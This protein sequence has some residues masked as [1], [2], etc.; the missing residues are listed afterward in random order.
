M[1]GEQ[2]YVELLL[3][4]RSRNALFLCRRSCWLQHYTEVVWWDQRTLQTATAVT[5]L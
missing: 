4:V 2:R 5:L 3:R 1:A